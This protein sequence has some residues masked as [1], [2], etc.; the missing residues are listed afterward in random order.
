MGSAPVITA[1]TDSNYQTYLN[2]NSIMIVWGQ[3][4]SL[5][6]SNVVRLHNTSTNADYYFQDNSGYYFWDQ[7]L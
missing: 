1:I 4:F 2:S 5:R 7:G 3:G 6:Q